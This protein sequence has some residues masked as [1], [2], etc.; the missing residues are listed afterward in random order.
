MTCC[1]LQKAETCSNCKYDFKRARAGD[2]K[3]AGVISPRKIITMPPYPD[4][5]LPALTYSIQEFNARARGTLTG[6]ARIPE[7][8]NFALAGRARDEDGEKR[9]NID[10]FKDCEQLHVRNDVTITR[11]YDS[12]IGITHN[13]PFCGPF[14]IY[15]APNFR[16]C[17]VR[18]NHLRKRIQLPASIL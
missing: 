9:V 5:Q 12:V 3:E 14:S 7:F 1:V 17:L 18:S 11:D 6:G 16:D 10:V 8:V 13:L 4:E 15:P 2:I